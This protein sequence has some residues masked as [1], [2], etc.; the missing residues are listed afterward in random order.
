MIDTTRIKDIREDHDIT[1]MEMAKILNIKRSTYSMWEVGLSIMPLDK[2]CEFAKFF[3][4]SIDYVLGLSN[5]RNINSIRN[6]DYLQ[7][8]KNIKFLREKINL[9]QNDLAK[10]I[11]VTQACIVRWEKGVT[12]I[13]LSNLYKLSKLFTVTL[14]E[15]CSSHE[16][17]FQ[18][19]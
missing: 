13:S 19:V 14:N 16:D 7:L 5:N 1:Q 8:G 11:N 2:L 18:I 4:Y 3:N 6:F 17:I 12:K 10:N 9:S 15:L